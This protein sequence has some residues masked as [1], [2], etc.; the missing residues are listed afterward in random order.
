MTTPN[1][2]QAVRQNPAA[3]QAGYAASLA[4]QPSMPAALVAGLSWS[5]PRPE[6]RLVSDAL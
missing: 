5:A 6:L 1:A 3:S 2:L 4:G